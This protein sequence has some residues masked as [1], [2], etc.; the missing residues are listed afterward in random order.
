M[1]P[2]T[3]SA[4]D[5]QLSISIEHK[6]LP[7]IQA[8]MKLYLAPY[9]AAI[10]IAAC[11]INR[12]DASIARSSFSVGRKASFGLS[13]EV[14]LGKIPRGGSEE[15]EVDADVPEVLYLPGLLEATIVKR[16]KVRLILSCF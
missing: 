15:A 6:S 3:F 13:S 12:V 4:C 1:G 2:M 5:V 16:D 14:I 7:L 10:G 9:L 11:A 8:I